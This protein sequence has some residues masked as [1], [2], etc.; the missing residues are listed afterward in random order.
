MNGYKEHKTPYGKGVSITDA[1]E[2]NRAI[3]DK[4]VTAKPRLTGAE[5]RFLRKQMDLSQKG[6]AD[7]MGIEALQVCRWETGKPTKM[8]D[9]FLRHIY[10]EKLGGNPNINAIVEKLNQRDQDRYAALKFSH[11]SHSWKSAA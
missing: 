4:L 5:F 9:R 11:R 10:T 6:L 3:A 7:L 8:A 1:D 2:L